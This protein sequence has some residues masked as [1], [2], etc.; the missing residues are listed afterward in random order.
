[1]YTI[2]DKDTDGD[3]LTMFTTRS[4][5]KAI[6]YIKTVADTQVLIRDIARIHVEIL[7]GFSCG[8]R[9]DW[10]AERFENGSFPT[11]DEY[12]EYL[13]DNEDRFELGGYTVTVDD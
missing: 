9:I 11:P 8:E 4:R 13:F 1:M 12:I 6:D 3:I 2:C 5:D 10:F 7:D